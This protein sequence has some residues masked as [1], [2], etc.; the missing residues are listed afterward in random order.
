MVD[1]V[2]THVDVL[3]GN[4]ILKDSAIVVENGYIKEFVT[5]D[6]VPQAKEVIDGK[7]MLAAP[8]LINTHTHIAMGLLRNYADDLELMDWLQTAIW[9]AEAK[10]NNHLVYWGTQLG[11][12][13]MFRSGTTC[14]SDMYFF[15]DQTA[16]A[17]KETGIRA[18][19][20]RGM[21]GVAPTAEQALVESKELFEAYHGYNQDQI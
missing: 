11:I 17:I 13:E 16:E 6:T 10:L 9:P 14:F 4:T 21:A 18:V 2:I 12:A 1:V 15:M 19:L 8:G 3:Q 7:G 5:N 20:S